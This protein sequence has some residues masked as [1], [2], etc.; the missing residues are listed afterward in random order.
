[1]QA[2]AIQVGNRDKADIGI[3]FENIVEKF[4]SSRQLLNGNT[5]FHSLIELCQHISAN[6]FSLLFKFRNNLRLKQGPR[7]DRKTCQHHQQQKDR[8]REEPETDRFCEIG[9]HAFSAAC[10][11]S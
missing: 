11:N 3:I 7:E 6:F 4:I 9:I 8:E 2:P 10:F 1:M 5:P